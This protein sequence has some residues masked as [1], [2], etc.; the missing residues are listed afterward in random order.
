MTTTETHATTTTATVGEPTRRGYVVVW[1]ALVGLAIA[2]LLASRVVTGSAGLAISLGIAAVKATLVAAFFMHLARGR[3]VHR[4]AFAA[5]VA[6]FLL[7]VLGI[8]ADVGTRSIASAYVDDFGVPAIGVP[9]VGSAA[10]S[11][12]DRAE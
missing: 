2:S 8:V 12:G 4:L 6:F 1:L 3:A 10:G 7:L 11:L 5:A 9:A